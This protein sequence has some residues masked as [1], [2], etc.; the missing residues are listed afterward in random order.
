MQC[1]D[2]NSILC[3]NNYLTKTKCILDSFA[4]CLYYP[5]DLHNTLNEYYGIEITQLE[6]RLAFVPV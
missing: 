6:L 4:F 5:F 2:E 1:K 3:Y